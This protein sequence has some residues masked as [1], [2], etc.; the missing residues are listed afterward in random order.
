MNCGSV[1]KPKDGDPR[2][3]LAVLEAGGDGAR[4][5]IERVTYDDCA[6]AEHM[7]RVELPDQLADAL[8]LAA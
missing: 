3:S 6:V 2:A 4:V 7:R 8:P 5:T 1:G